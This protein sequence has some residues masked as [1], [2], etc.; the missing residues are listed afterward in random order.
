MSYRI[1]ISPNTIVKF[2]ANYLEDDGKPTKK[3]SHL[4][5]EVDQSRQ[6]ALLLKIT[7][8]WKNYFWQAKLGSVKCLPKPSF[9]TL[10]RIII[11]DLATLKK[12][13]RKFR[14]CQIHSNNC[15]EK[16]RFDKIVHKLKKFWRNPLNRDKLKIRLDWRNLKI[17]EE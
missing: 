15:V 13:Y 17:I 12:D 2:Y 9:I 5:I 16:S 7:S 11:F 8:K 4:V 6:E 1:K 14:I 10:N 3:R